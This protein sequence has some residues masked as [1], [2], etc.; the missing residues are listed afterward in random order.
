M[1]SLLS[2]LRK[3]LLHKSLRVAVTLALVSVAGLLGM[4]MWHHYMVAPWTRDG[5][6]RAEAV[7]IAPE[8]AGTVIEVKVHDNQLVKKGDVLFVIDPERYRL[9]LAQA[10]ANMVSRRHDMEVAASRA[11]R[12]SRLSE[13]AVSIEDREQ[14]SGT[15]ASAG[16]V[17]EA[18][19][20]QAN[21]AKLNLERTVIRAPVNGYVTNLHLR[22]GDYANVGQA[23]VTV[24]D[25]DSFWV[26]GY[27]EETKLAGIHP[28]DSARIDLMGYDVPLT[29]RV[30]SIS[31]GISDQND[32]TGSRGLASV[33][34]VFSWVRLAQRI[35]VRIELGEVPAGV[36]LAA[37]MTCTVR[38]GGPAR[39]TDD[40]RLATHALTRG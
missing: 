27:F 37:G 21:L 14:S 31:R 15:A 1:P 9:A 32:Q 33:D 11:A 36:T 18:A 6:I 35:P 16:A 20:A 2:F 24:V 28:G 4:A 23:A 7:S 22:V 40:L 39:F 26:A 17:V 25:R 38:V 10:Q 12:R 13:M 29:G 5:R 8:V 30:Q 19:I 34:P 3:P